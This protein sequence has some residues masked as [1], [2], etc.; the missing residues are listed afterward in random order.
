VLAVDQPLQLVHDA[1]ELRVRSGRR[2]IPYLLHLGRQYLLR[3]GS[4]VPRLST[5]ATPGEE[6]YADRT[7][8]RSKPPHRCTSF[9]SW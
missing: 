7:D 6:N 1:L 8:D 5:A 9:S 2:D 4:Q 3:G